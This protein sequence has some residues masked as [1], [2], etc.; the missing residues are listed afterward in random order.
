MAV[1]SFYSLFQLRDLLKIIPFS[2]QYSTTTFLVLIYYDSM[3][4]HFASASIS[5]S[6][7][8]TCHKGYRWGSHTYKGTAHAPKTDIIGG[9]CY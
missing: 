5:A 1:T 6:I 4:S 9:Q 7:L 8:H 2:A 3:I